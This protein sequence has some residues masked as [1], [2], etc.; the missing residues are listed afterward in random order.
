MEYKPDL[1]L[2]SA[3]YD[4]HVLDP[5]GDQQI[6]TAGFAL[7]SQ[8]LLELSKATGAKVV[9]I[10]E[11]GYHEGA[12]GESVLATLR[13]LSCDAVEQVKNMRIASL[14]APDGY[15]LK[16]VTTDQD[17]SDVDDHIEFAR[18]RLAQFWSSLRAR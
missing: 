15:S 18:Q 11:G 17:V 8:R 13:I 14:S 12:L 6:T 7:L 3:G 16:A 2:L 1:I 5:L 10:L 9:A 4:A